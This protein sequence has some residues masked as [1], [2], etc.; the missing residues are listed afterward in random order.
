M[1]T[2]TWWQPSGLWQVTSA[3]REIQP[4]CALILKETFWSPC[5]RRNEVA[6][7]LWRL[8]VTSRTSSWVVPPLKVVFF[9]DAPGAKLSER[10]YCSS[11]DWVIGTSQRGV[12][13]WVRRRIRRDRLLRSRLGVWRSRSS[14][15]T[16]PSQEERNVGPGPNAPSVSKSADTPESWSLQVGGPVGKGWGLQSEREQG[17]LQTHVFRQHRCRYVMK[18]GAA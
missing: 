10:L 2:N 18:A 6:G 17:P 16:T 8:L 3:R 12:F 1:E 15:P 14:R 7:G 4:T 9:R 13:S 5:G 11:A